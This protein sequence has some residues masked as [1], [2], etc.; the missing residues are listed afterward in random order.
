MARPSP[1]RSLLIKSS[2][3]ATADSLNSS[4]PAVEAG[5]YFSIP[6]SI[7]RSAQKQ[8]LVRRLPLECLLVETDSP[9]LGPQADQRN[10]PANLKVA[11]AAIAE[12]KAISV[13]EV[14][15]AVTANT[16]RLYGDRLSSDG[17]DS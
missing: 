4:L 9:V 5:Y 15:A 17:G 13:S 8:K 16:V 14:T 6:A 2:A 3:R 1:S 12:I 7:V 10:E 11:V